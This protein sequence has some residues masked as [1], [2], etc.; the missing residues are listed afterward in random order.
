M[1]IMSNIVVHILNIAVI[2]DICSL[3]NSKRCPK[4]RFLKQEVSENIKQNDMTN[5]CT[6]S[7]WRLSNLFRVV[8]CHIPMTSLRFDLLKATTVF[9]M[10]M[11]AHVTSMISQ[12]GI[13]SLRFLYLWEFRWDKYKNS[14]LNITYYTV[15]RKNKFCYP[16]LTEV[17]F[18]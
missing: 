8:P 14:F 2:F 17:Q 10:E 12:C 4:K 9:V 1:Q 3:L 11:S 18:P 13:V 16:L 7:N 5:I 6:I 15:V